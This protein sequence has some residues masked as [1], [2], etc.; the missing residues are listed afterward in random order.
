MVKKPTFQVDPSMNYFYTPNGYIVPAKFGV[1]FLP[2]TK[3]VPKRTKLHLNEIGLNN[4]EFCKSQNQLRQ[5][6]IS[7]KICYVST[8]LQHG[9]KIKRNSY[10][11]HT[12]Q[13]CL[14]YI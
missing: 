7:W 13:I 5:P 11:M 10:V 6:L 1:H 4:T 12:M 9:S 14:Y 3:N 2:L 8:F